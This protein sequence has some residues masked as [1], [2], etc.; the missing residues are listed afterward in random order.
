MAASILS[1]RI[2]V[3]QSNT[4][5]TLL[6]AASGAA[7][8]LTCG[9]TV[10]VHGTAVAERSLDCAVP[11]AT[12]RSTGGCSSLAW[13]CGLLD[14]AL[15]IARLYRI[16]RTGSGYRYGPVTI[17]VFRLVEAKIGLGDA[18]EAKKSRAILS[19]GTRQSYTH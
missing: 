11:I 12:D 19:T 9:V 1:P 5:H 7:L 10:K 17:F 15:V 3:L 13:A 6:R 8:C 14:L 16:L 2:D 18:R 4:R